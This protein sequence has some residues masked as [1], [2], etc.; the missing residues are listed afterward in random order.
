[1]ERLFFLGGFWPPK[2]KYQLRPVCNIFTIGNGRVLEGVFLTFERMWYVP[3]KK[4][5]QLI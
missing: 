4:D 5:M 1:M 3:V 2:P